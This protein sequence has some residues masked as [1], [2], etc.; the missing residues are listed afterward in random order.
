E[1]IPVYRDGLSF[2]LEV[3]N[4]LGQNDCPAAVWDAIDPKALAK[5]LGA[6]EVVM[7]GPRF[8]VM[9][10]I[11]ASGETKD[12]ETKVFDGLAATQRA[13]LSL[14]F[15]DIIFGSRPYTEKTI[16]RD[17]TYVYDAG[18]PVYE[19]TDD[20]GNVYVM[21]TFAEIVDKDLTMDDLA[22]L[23]DRLKL[24]R[25]WSYKSRVLDAEL[26]LTASGEAYLIQDELQ[27]SY[28]RRN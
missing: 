24:P 12:G 20:E 6:A 4:T 28:Q 1:I 13:T 9:D 2:R 7:N 14:P 23:G 8:W 17:T 27:N 10:R 19:I 18:K 11:I 15:R 25:G 3:Y 22:G 26:R 21:Q 16:N 5:E